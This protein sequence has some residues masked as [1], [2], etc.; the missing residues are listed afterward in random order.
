MKDVPFEDMTSEEVFPRTTA[1]TTL[2]GIK[3]MAALYDVELPA[4]I[5]R[6]V[7]ESGKR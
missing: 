3:L 1:A 7:M 5:E 2:L 6:K 4:D